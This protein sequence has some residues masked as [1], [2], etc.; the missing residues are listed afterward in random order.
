M[1]LKIGLLSGLGIVAS[2]LALYWL[3]PQTSGGQAL[4]ALI[5]FAVVNGVGG[6]IWRAKS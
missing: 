1:A 5:V 6:L 3:E 2:L 4:L